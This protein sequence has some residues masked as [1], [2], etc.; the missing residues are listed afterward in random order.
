MLITVIPAVIGRTGI[1]EGNRPKGNKTAIMTR[2]R[3]EVQE[4]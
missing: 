3:G 1:M 4:E 2:V